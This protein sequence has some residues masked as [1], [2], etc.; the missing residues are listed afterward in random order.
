MARRCRWIIAF[1]YF[2]SS[3][4]L[5][6]CGGSSLRE[7]RLGKLPYSWGKYLQAGSI[8]ATLAVYDSSGKAMLHQDLAVD[9]SEGLVS[10]PQFKLPIGGTYRFI[11]IFDYSLSS[12]EAIPYA[13]ADFT[14]LVDEFREFYENNIRSG[15]FFEAS[16]FVTA[17]M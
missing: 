17:D 4:I 10:A 3:L 9:M 13:Y 11:I 14:W 2:C 1:L 6:Q 7:G 15:P 16:N 8:T 5:S 12:T